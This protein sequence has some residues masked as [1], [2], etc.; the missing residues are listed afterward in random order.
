MK[1]LLLLPVIFITGFSFGQVF[2][3]GVTDIDG[4]YYETVIIGSQEWMADN[5]R[6]AKYS[7]GDVI[8]NVT[9]N[10]E[11]SNL[12]SGAW[13]HYNNDSQHENPYGKLYNWFT[14]SDSRNVCPNGWHVP[15]SE[16]WSILINFLDPN[17]D[18]GF[19]PN[20]AGGKMKG[21]GTNFWTA[22]NLDA[23]NDTGFTGLP[24][25]SRLN[26]GS[27]S[28]NLG[29]F[30]FWWSSTDLDTNANYVSTRYLMYLNG[31]AW[32]NSNSVREGISVR[33]VLGQ[34]I[35]VFELQTLQ[36]QL[37]K[38]VNLLGQEVEYSPNT[39]LIY[40]YDDGSKERI[41]KLEE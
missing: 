22:P 11:W 31:S 8:P 20:T 15:T 29:E 37:I 14:I 12:T 34:S 28:E 17:A 18:G 21:T 9:S 33:C 32:W 27:F 13:A 35:G 16:E 36:K 30:G 1:I 10:I 25:A 38:I 7:N 5:L 41:M 19:N 23:I 2:G 3:D 24:G 39:V 4:N 26:D 6:V 40:V